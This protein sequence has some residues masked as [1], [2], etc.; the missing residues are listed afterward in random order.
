MI[1]LRQFWVSAEIKSCDRLTRAGYGE[2]LA[3]KA[4]VG[5]AVRVS[6]RVVR[7]SDV[8]KSGNCKAKPKVIKA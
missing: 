1:S 3:V 7:V 4:Q 2:T 6:L 5:A 8:K